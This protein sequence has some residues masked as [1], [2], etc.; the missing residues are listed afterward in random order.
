M[1]LLLKF[2]LF[3]LLLCVTICFLLFVKVVENH[4]EKINYLTKIVG[5]TDDEFTDIKDYN[6]EQLLDLDNFEYVIRPP[7]CNTTFITWIV[8]SYAA[9]PAPRS[10]HRR[11]YISA[12]LRS[13]G[14][15]RVFLLG[16]LDDRTQRKSGV[17]QAAIENEAERFNDIVQGNFYEAYRNLTYKHLMGLKWATENCRDSSFIVKQD[18]DIVVNIY[19]IIDKITTLKSQG[20]DVFAGHVFRNMKVIREPSNK[21]FVTRDEFAGKVYPNFLSGWMYIVDH[22]IAEK[23]VRRSRNCKK[24]FW[25][26]DA[27][28]TGILRQDLNIKLIDIREMFAMDYRYLNCCIK[29]KEKKLTCEFAVGPNGGITE[30][31]VTFQDFAKF[32]RNL[33]NARSV[34]H[35]IGE[36][37]IN[38]HEQSMVPIGDA[39]IQPVQFL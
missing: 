27:F 19:D 38:V 36:T 10:A 24:Y 39:Q 21:W 4:Y 13:L 31:Q 29:G 7:S 35:S 33:C 25:I 14:I 20:A 22:S 18:D 37:C 12:E 32:C 15:S 2:S 5:V 9:D 3:F 1:T 16:L 23:I 28:V 26:D 8:T 34:G 6:H 17:I 30:L 11:A